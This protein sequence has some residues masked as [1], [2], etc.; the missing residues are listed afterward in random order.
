MSFLFKK[1]KNKIFYFD[2]KIK[3]KLV[4]TYFASFVTLLTYIIFR[5]IF[6]RA[7]FLA[8]LYLQKLI[9][10]VKSFAFFHTFP[11]IKFT[12]VI[13]NKVKILFWAFFNTYFL[14][15]ISFI[16]VIRNW[17]IQITLILLCKKIILFSALRASVHSLICTFGTFTVTIRTNL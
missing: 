14:I 12:Y 5:I 17:T 4:K 16:P 1:I 15:F 2:I 7:L 11:F 8:V 6:L 13:T 9:C 3:K 10:V